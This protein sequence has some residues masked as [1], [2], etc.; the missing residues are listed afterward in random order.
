MPNHSATIFDT[1]PGQFLGIPPKREIDVWLGVLVLAFGAFAFG[2][3]CASAKEDVAD[4][5]TKAENKLEA[6]VEGL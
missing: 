4:L 2:A 1:P 6:W 5:G 3:G